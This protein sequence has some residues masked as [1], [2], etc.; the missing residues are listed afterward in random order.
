MKSTNTKKLT[1]LAM[2]SA[3]AFLLAL[4]FHYLPV[5]PLVP[6]APFLKFEPKDVVIAIAGFLYGPLAVIPMAVVV[7]V[8]EMPLSATWIYG[9]IMNVA[10]TCA[11]ACTA[12]LIYKFRRTIGGAAI[13]LAAGTVLTVVVMVPLNYLI[14][15]F[16]MGI[17]RHAVVAILFTGIGLFN[18]VKYALIA[19]ITM[20]LYIPLKA[21]LVKSK[22]LPESE[23]AAGKPVKIS[24]ISVVVSLLVVAVCALGILYLNGLL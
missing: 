24:I 5:P 9:L 3:L 8:L 15:P 22:L 19:A 7:G 21:A 1:T 14:T 11:F 20:Q 10:S 2:L 12:A 4:L 16:F 13:G 23:T 6:A 18:F 17:P